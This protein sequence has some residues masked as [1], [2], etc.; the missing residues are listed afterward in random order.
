MNNI[1]KALREFVRRENETLDVDRIDIPLPGLPEALDGYRMAVVTD[2]H[3]PRFMPYHETILHSI[4]LER[5][6]CILLV[7]DSIDENTHSVFALEPFFTTLASIAPVIAVLGNNDCDKDHTP[8]LRTMYHNAGVTL[9]ENE[10]RTLQANGSFIRITGLQDPMAYKRGVFVDRAPDGA[11]HIPISDALA[12]EMR[13][14]SRIPSVLLIHQ[15]QLAKEYAKLHPSLIVSGHAHGGQFRLPG[16]GGLFSPGQGPLPRLTSGLYPLGE[17][18][19]LVSRGLGNHDF[20]IRLGNRPHL[21]VAVL[22]RESRAF[23]HP[24]HSA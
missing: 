1:K 18:N 8:Q 3:M 9:L 11:K 12:P 10:T 16:I 17:T 20:Y 7:G 6:G 19:L 14:S 24:R 21:P 2:L 13:E 5:P 23:L 22:R 4:A 15:P